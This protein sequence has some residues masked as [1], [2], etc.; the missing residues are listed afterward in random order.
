MRGRFAGFTLIEMLA[1][2]ALGTLL[3]LAAM[4]VLRSLAP[5]PTTTSAEAAPAAD[6]LRLVRWDLANARRFESSPDGVTLWGLGSLNPA[7]MSPTH[8]PTVVRYR[9]GEFAGT[10]SLLRSEE[11]LGAAMGQAS[12]PQLICPGVLAFSIEPLPEADGAPDAQPF[13]RNRGRAL[14]RC[15][16]V[17][18][19]DQS[20]A[21]T[22]RVICLR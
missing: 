5:R 10:A 7:D 14:P 17:R 20:G 2:L 3:M 4:G 15:V 6:V 13:E 8:R 16:E 19:T 21:E 11:P 22:R 12:G 18:W 9:V 1:A